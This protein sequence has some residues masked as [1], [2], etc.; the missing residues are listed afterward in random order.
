ME[1]ATVQTRFTA[2]TKDFD[3]KTKSVSSKIS[4][5]A[6]SVAKGIAVA[7]GAATVAVGKMVS[8]SVKSFAEYEQLEGGLESLFGKGSEEMNKILQ[9]SET[10]YKDLTMSQNDYL[11][12]FEGTYSIMKNGLGENADAI[13]YTN[14]MISISSD[15]YNTYG[16]SVEQYSNAINWALK[17]TYSYIDNLNIG[18]K[19]TQEGFIEAANSS[20][21]LGREIKDVS[22]LTNDEII[23]V[24][25]FY[26]NSAGAIGKTQKEASTTIQGSLNMMKSSWQDLQTQFAKGGDLSKPIDNFVQSAKTFADQILPIIETVL[27]SISNAL[28]GLVDKINEILPGLIEGVL[29][30][31]IQAVVSLV[32]GL[33]KALPSLIKTL[34]P[35]LI[36]GLLSITTEIIKLLPDIIIMIAEMLPSLMPQIIDA[37][38]SIIPLLIDNLPL[39]LSAGAQLLGG[40]IAGIVNS[41]PILLARIGEIVVKMINSFKTIDLKQI[42]KDILKGLWNGLSSMKDWVVDKVK[43]IG[44]SILSGLKGILG[45]KSPSKEFAIIGRYSILGYTEALDDMQS[46]VQKQVAETFSISPQLS[47]SSGMHFSPN[48]INN[49]YVDIQQDPLGQ[50]V[51]SIKTY[52]GGAKNDFNYGAGL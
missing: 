37:I 21:V 25:E 27:I 43:S 40:L 32:N 28:P 30:S 42:G 17:G 51:N 35:P 20:G 4:S 18:I 3:T 15:L 31:L 24:I 16:G 7:T 19:G 49:N 5:I 2:D 23:D 52:S 10:A 44:K 26:A 13:E 46:D 1:G 39:F 6:S 9:T 50:M 11:K 22:D 38:L 12:S 33:I 14:K 8:D 34:L 29:P 41:I 45:I 47:A 36:E 48:I